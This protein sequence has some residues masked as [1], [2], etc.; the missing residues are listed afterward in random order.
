MSGDLVRGEIAGYGGVAQ[1]EV[2]SRSRPMQSLYRRPLPPALV[3]FAAPEGRALFDAARAEGGMEAFFP[4]IEQFHTQADPAFC[5]LGT[6]VVALNA[7]GVDPGRLWKGPWRWFSEEMLDCCSPLE[8]V[9]ARGITLD[10]LACLARCNGAAATLSRATADNVTAFRATLR[11]AARASADPVL[12]V[13]YDRSVLGQ[14]GVGHFSPIGGYHE[15][16]DHAL[17]LD[18][19][20]FKYPPHWVSVTALHAAM[21][22]LDPATGRPRG[23]VELRRSPRPASLLYTARCVGDGGFASIREGLALLREAVARAPTDS[24]PAALRSIFAVA[25]DIPVIVEHGQLA[26]SEHAAAAE[27]LQAALRETAVYRLVAEVA[28]PAWPAEAATLLALALPTELWDPLPESL[29]AAWL[30]V[31][32]P[33]QLPASVRAESE[34]V[35]GQLADLCALTAGS[36][37][38]CG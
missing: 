28:P 27:A 18:V 31:L 30:A 23:W 36:C 4:L 9:R 1:V 24:L 20:R 26:L 8:R 10:E 38:R 7:L 37:E 12:I 22:A 16:S 34:H 25:R 14:T 19:A 6:L 17:V 29:R 13:S 11:A 32:D 35:H 21:Q 2:V 33:R 5:G 15:A 3:A